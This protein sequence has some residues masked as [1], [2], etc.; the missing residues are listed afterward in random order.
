M[1]ASEIFIT[2]QGRIYHLG[3]KPEELARQILIGGDPDRAD[4]IAAHF[5][6]IE[7]RVQS[8]E[9][10]SR[11]GKVN[12][13]PITVISTGI[14]TDNNEI[15]LVESYALNEFDLDERVR[16]GGALPL[17]VIRVGT[18]GGIQPENEPGTLAIG[19]YGLGLDNTGMF[20][21]ARAADRIVN[22]IEEEAYLLLTEATPQDRRFRGKIIP[23]ASKADPAVVAALE[24]NVIGDSVT[25]ITAS[26]SGF[27]GPQGREVTGLRL[28]IP[29][30][31]EEIAKL[32]IDGLKVVNFEMES[33]LLFHL[34]GHM[35]YRSAT[36][37]PLINNRP[38][39]TAKLDYSGDV[40]R[41]IKTALDAMLEL[42]NGGQ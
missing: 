21:D 20:Y 16:K 34:A 11:T 10:V 26:A 13:M 24:N 2:E 17:T 28:T 18:S 25:G 14:G 5:D 39:G 32:D 3:M 41:C 1:K 12:G 4:L 23:Y 42:Y 19:S 6:T 38:K 37:C 7:H 22:L 15:M 9:F 31:Q 40:E 36:I 33:S 8:R 30:L 27:F 35:N 29:G